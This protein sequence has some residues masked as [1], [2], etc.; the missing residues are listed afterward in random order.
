MSRE[1]I[2]AFSE[3]LGFGEQR[4]PRFGSIELDLAS[5]SVR[6]G[7]RSERLAPM[8]YQILWMLVRAQGGIVS[9][10]EIREFVY[11]DPEID[12]PQGDALSPRLAPLRKKLAKVDD[13]I[14]I[15]S[16]KGIGYRLVSKQD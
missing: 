4:D 12:A 10:A 8:E 15:E 16:M 14:A 7:D 11:D 13:T 1:G 6:S 5:H 3:R 9:E 2:P